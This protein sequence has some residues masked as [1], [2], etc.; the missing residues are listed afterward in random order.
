M[1]RSSRT[2]GWFLRRGEPLSDERS[3]AGVVRW[4][5]AG[6]L[7]IGA[8]LG[9]WLVF[10][11]GGVPGDPA[12]GGGA[13]GAPGAG[14]SRDAE[15]RLSFTAER[16]TQLVSDR[17]RALALLENERLAEVE[18]L[19]V[20][21]VEELPDDPLPQRNLAVC[22]LLM[23]QAGQIDA[24]KAW[25]AAERSAGPERKSAAGLLLMGRVAAL[26]AEKE[27]DGAARAKWTERATGAFEAATALDARSP[28]PWYELYK[29]LR[30][31]RE[32]EPV[33]RARRAIW[34]ASE[35]AP[36][37]LFVL[38]D[39]LQSL[40]EG[41]SP[42][43][44]GVIERARVALGPVQPG[45]LKRARVDVFRFLEEAKEL[46]AAGKWPEATGK[47]RV[48]ATVTRPE[49]FAQSDRKLVD[50]YPLEFVL[51]E[52]TLPALTSRPMIG[53]NAAR[54]PLPKFTARKFTGPLGEF[55]GARDLVACDV[56]LDGL[57]DVAVL[58][59]TLSGD[60]TPGQT[61]PGQSTLGLFGLEGEAGSLWLGKVELAGSFRGLAMGDLDRDTTGR[62][63]AAA[64][65]AASDS[66]PVVVGAPGCF[67]AAPDFVVWG[68]AGIGV[69]LNQPAEAGADASLP[70]RL[71]VV[72][73]TEGLQELRDVTA[74]ALV[75]V[76]QEGDLD[77]VVGTTTGVTI[78]INR[79]DLQFENI[80]ARSTL[81]GDLSAVG[82]L[83]PVDWDRDIDLDLVLVGPKLPGVCLLENLRHG[84]FR[85]VPLLGDRAE[86]SVLG[87]VGE[88]DGNASWD[89]VSWTEGTALLHRSE[90]PVRGRTS[91]LPRQLL[92]AAKYTRADYKPVEM[93]A[94][95]W[96]SDGQDDLVVRGETGI[97]F[98]P[99]WETGG[100]PGA[101]PLEWDRSMAVEG[102]ATAVTE[103][104]L[105]GDQDLD[106]LTAGP[107]GVRAIVNTGLDDIP[108]LWVRVFGENDPQS[109]RVNQYNLGGLLEVRSGDH[110]QARVIRGQTTHFGLGTRTPEM[111]RVLFTNGVP[112]AAVSPKPGTVLCE[113]QILKG[114][115]PYLYTWTGE[116][117]E[118]FTDLLWAAPLGLQIAEDVILP[119][120]P[121]EYLKVD[122]EKLVARDGRYELRITSEL[123]E[124]DYFDRVELLAI[125][126]PAEIEV[127]SNE[128]VG[129]PDL[130][131]FGVH[132]V[133]ERKPVVAARDQTG[134]DVMAEVRADDG[135]YAKCFS[136]TLKQG[137]TEPHALEL[138]LGE[139]DGS[140]PV[141]LFLRGWIFP[142]DTSLNVAFTQDP[143]LDGPKPPSLWVM[144]VSG[145][146]VE[147]RP[148][149]GFPGG[150]PKTIAVDLTG[151]FPTD[152]HRLQIRTS[153][154]LYWDSAF[155]T[156]GERPVSESTDTITIT[157]LAM[158]R[159]ELAYRGF[160]EVTPRGER[161]PETIDY[162]RVSGAAKWPPM[163]GPFTRYGGVLELLTG[164]DDKM[165]L[166]SPGDELRLEFEV[167]PEVKPGWKRDFV[168]H[169]VG[170]DKDAD[171]HTVYG[172]TVE[173]LPF[174]A[175]TR[176]P[177][178]AE[179]VPPGGAEYEAY[180][181]TYQTREQPWGAFRRP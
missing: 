150:K 160:S 17:N 167:G 163:V 154:E 45:I 107:E 10:F 168:L 62:P 177:F 34:S 164:W 99:G 118:F 101:V 5:L 97:G 63:M 131:A 140:Q 15:G 31:S 138:D 53:P 161:T 22:R 128:K 137:L 116:R 181:K 105:D 151:V 57:V 122:G 49:E 52:F 165:V 178:G 43:L 36:N 42:E 162:G 87:A 66:K 41:K 78:W 56:N 21:L 2:T 136:K 92:F 26:A 135:V 83:I 33:A 76:D 35:R 3:G 58:G 8:G 37:N 39:A 109:G 96:N 121:W 106:F 55:A 88:F 59:E 75:D 174:K 84:E 147:S 71:T 48:V 170:W 14:P 51:T 110:Y 40:A 172:Q 180:L 169:S 145:E 173:P 19:W 158:R 152:D 179:D 175:M 159:A 141:T 61:T 44:A 142:S 124:A 90:T 77:L 30:Y 60:A 1:E 64:A 86:P 28:L 129:P 95:D 82:E 65:P 104:N 115:C 18:P 24:E 98:V 153:H 102:V 9:V 171:L 143:T 29:S 133:R 74:L 149:M 125:D 119:D 72:A 54:P 25:E 155:Y 38:A 114:S 91:L 100:E 132:P 6:V 47:L 94:C 68:P 134:R 46:I 166:M 146:W 12:G 70:R 127:F 117:F 32:A 81:S 130:A 85:L 11:R 79:G 113:K 108:A 111:L 148:F 126:H 120:R 4:F 16:L 23:L 50:P 176:Y 7:L 139:F 13:G 73:Q 80:S 103:I 69:Y 123:W 20:R 112:Q 89:L 27:A 67:E 157:P 93:I 156:V 144:G